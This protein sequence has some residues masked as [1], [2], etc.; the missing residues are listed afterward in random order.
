MEQIDLYIELFKQYRSNLQENGDP[1][2]RKSKSDPHLS[3]IL[4]NMEF[5]KDV[6]STLFVHND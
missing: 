4:V 1:L 6:F 2:Y 3:M 5:E